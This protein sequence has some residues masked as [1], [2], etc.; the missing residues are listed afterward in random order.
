MER[1]LEE[2]E[3]DTWM[4]IFSSVPLNNIEI[5]NYF[6]YEPTITHKNI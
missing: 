2:Q 6:K 3:E 1:E 4:K 5:T